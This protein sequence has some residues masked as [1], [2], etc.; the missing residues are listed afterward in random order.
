MFATLTAQ[1]IQKIQTTVVITWTSA[2]RIRMTANVDMPEY[3]LKAGDTFYLVRS[4]KN[5]GLYYIVRWN[6]DRIGWQCPCPATKRCRHIELVSLDCGSR[7][8]PITW[9][10]TVQPAPKEPTVEASLSPWLRK[11]MG[12]KSHNGTFSGKR[13]A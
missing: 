2:P 12:G 1:K 3:G 5:D 6:Y 9:Q 10:P 8:A 13:V 7:K 11:V 4:S